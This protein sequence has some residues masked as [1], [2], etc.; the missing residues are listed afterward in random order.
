MNFTLR[1]LGKVGF[2]STSLM[3][4]QSSMGLFYRV[5]GNVVQF[6]SSYVPQSL[7]FFQLTPSELKAFRAGKLSLVP[8][9]FCSPSGPKRKKTD[10][11]IVH[12]GSVRN[13]KHLEQLFSNVNA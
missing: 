5:V 9:G 8:P 10:A 7:G 4:S 3:A 11:T 12:T 6:V 13:I 1:N 2:K